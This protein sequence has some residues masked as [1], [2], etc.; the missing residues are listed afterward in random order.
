MS[1]I[2]NRLLAFFVIWVVRPLSIV[3]FRYVLRWR[4]DPLPTTDKFIL[5]AAPHTSNWD[6]VYML[7]TAML[8]KR[9]IYWLG[10]KELF[11]TRL[12]NWF[13]RLIGGLP[14]DRSSPLSALRDS[15]HM[16]EQHER[17]ML[18]IAPEGTRGYTDGWKRGFHMLARKAKV[19]ILFT[20]LDYGQRHAM[21]GP[22]IEPS[23]NPQA[24]LEGVLGFYE[25]VVALHP[26][27]M[28]PIRIT[29]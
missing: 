21:V 26:D 5:I 3:W 23:K 22:M 29:D 19:P 16:I 15:V 11:K 1:R 17:I 4:A 20:R 14:V 2:I 9:K 8:S 18:A 27:R 10:K 28:A 6:I 13:L 7:Y 25:G 12:G 24:D